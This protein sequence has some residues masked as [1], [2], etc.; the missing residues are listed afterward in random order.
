MRDREKGRRYKRIMKRSEEGEK[1]K[2]RGTKYEKKE[3][4]LE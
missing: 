1:M 4:T 3:R 2:K